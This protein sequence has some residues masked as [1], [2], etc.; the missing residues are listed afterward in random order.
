MRVL[1]VTSEVATLYKIGGLGDVS[2]SLPVALRKLRVNVSVAMPYYRDIKLEKVKCVGQIAVDFDG[3]RELV[4]IFSSVIPGTTVPIYLFRHPKLDM[5]HGEDIVETFAFFSCAVARLIEFAPETLGG[6]PD[7][8]H[9]HDW[10]TGLVP[11]L[12]GESNKLRRE[13][14]TLESIRT[15][16]IITIHNLLYQG[17]APASLIKKLNLPKSMFHVLFTIRG[18]TIKLFREGLEH[19]DVISTVSP[20]YAKEILTGDYG[21]HVNDVLRRR[22]HDVVGILNGI[23]ENTW[24]PGHLNKSEEKMHLQEILRLPVARM[25]LIGF[26]GRLEVRQKG[27]DILIEALEHLLPDGVQVVILGTGPKKIKE[28]LTAFEKRYPEHFK[29]IPTFDERLARRIYAGADMLVVP[30]KFEPC[31]LTQMIAMRYGTIPLVRKTGGLADSVS[32]KKTGFVFEDYN[33]TALLAKCKEALALWS[34]RPATWQRMVVR[35]MKADFSWVKSAK[36]YKKLYGELGK[37]GK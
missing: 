14:A 2:Y 20:T 11:L 23:D 34:D 8:V 30:S 22:K 6:K 32:D 27:I 31:G 9:C 13:K 19:A 3:K 7:I 25:P 1:F 37:S 16:T 24:N 17:T 29:F 36:K 21:Q 12:L 15:K 33:S 18:L 5:Y 26:V 10:H 4:F 35:C 28:T